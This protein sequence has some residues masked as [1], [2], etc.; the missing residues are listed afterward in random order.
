MVHGAGLFWLGEC[1]LC[2]IYHVH[3]VLDMELFFFVLVG[4]LNCFFID[5]KFALVC[6]D[7][8]PY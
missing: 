6:E 8:C 4:M 3:S 7:I 1:L 2:E 5:L